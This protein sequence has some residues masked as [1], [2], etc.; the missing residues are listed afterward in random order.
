[1]KR[2]YLLALSITFLQFNL[3]AGE[4]S[5]FGAGNLNNPKPYGLTSTEEALLQN[6]KNLQQVVV[7]SNN[8]ANKVDSLRSRIDGLQS[9]IEGLSQKAQDNK[10]ALKSLSNQIDNKLK[11]SDEYEKRVG[12][13]TQLNNDI[14]Q[15]NIKDIEK[16]KL[17]ISEISLLI[18]TINALYVSKDE[19]N[20]L[21][22][23][24]NNFKDLVAGELKSKSASGSKSDGS[25]LSSMDNAEISDKAQE[26][27]EKKFYTKAI[28][29]YNYLIDKNYKPARA[30]YMIGEMNYYRKNY[31]DAIAYFKK[32]ASLYSDASYMPILMLHTARA[33]DY[34]GDKKN[35]KAFYNGIIAKY[36][37]T[38]Y[39]KD[40]K[41]YLSLMN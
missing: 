12:E 23:D 7:K 22:S 15:N 35:A 39:A 19:F 36:P 9:I 14:S 41:E 10:V 34:T 33:M 27:Y 38:K 13:I 6:K 17:V 16:L 25:S 26:F 8:Q 30:H 29:Y 2:S 31:S 1:M 32:S 3:V 18:D 5:A 21:V 40:S 24:V 28:E 20:K 37:D 4:P 11:G